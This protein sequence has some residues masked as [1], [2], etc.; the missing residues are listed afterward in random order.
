MVGSILI[1]CCV[2]AHLLTWR[3]HYQPLCLGIAGQDC[4]TTH[5]M[6]S[7]ETCYEIA[8]NAGTAL[9]VLLVNNP[10][11]NSGCTNIYPGEVCDLLNLK[12]N[13]IY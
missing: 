12:T 7:G 11:V 6:V 9:D 10:N 13:I 8:M 5:V 1:N 2:I 3:S 4:S